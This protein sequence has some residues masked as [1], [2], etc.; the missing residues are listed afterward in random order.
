MALCSACWHID[1][2][3]SCSSPFACAEAFVWYMIHRF[4]CICEGFALQQWLPLV[5]CNPERIPC[6]PISVQ[7][8]VSSFVLY[9]HLYMKLCLLYQYNGAGGCKCGR[10]HNFFVLGHNRVVWYSPCLLQA[11]AV[12]EGAPRYIEQPVVEARCWYIFTWHREVLMCVHTSASG[13]KRLM[14]CYPQYMPVS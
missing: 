1:L 10:C 4:A 7:H 9:E 13:V 3:L 5:V 14:F 2:G 11:L 12:R 6:C 8:A